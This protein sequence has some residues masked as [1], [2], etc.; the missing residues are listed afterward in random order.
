[1]VA[2]EVGVAGRMPTGGRVPPGLIAKLFP[3]AEGVDAGQ[4]ALEAGVALEG[5]GEDCPWSTAG[6][7][8]AVGEGFGRAV[9]VN[10]QRQAAGSD[11]GID[12]IIE[13]SADLG[14]D[15]LEI[16]ANGDFFA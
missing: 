2:M 12:R 4:L 13:G 3:G 8:V 14:A 11:D 15:D 16:G 9:I 10:P 7:D 1:N 5:V 6:I